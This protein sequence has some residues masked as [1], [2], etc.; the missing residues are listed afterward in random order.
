[1]FEGF[2]EF[3]ENKEASQRE[4]SE[5]QDIHPEGDGTVEDAKNYWDNIYENVNVDE[6]E[7][8]NQGQKVNEWKFN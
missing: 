6:T 7:V 3:T 1:M 2:G 5:Y 8:T 4:V